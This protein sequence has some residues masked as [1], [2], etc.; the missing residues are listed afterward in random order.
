LS[1]KA[2]EESILCASCGEQT[3]GDPCVRCGDA[4]LLE[5]RYRLHAVLARGA[6]GTTYRAVDQVGSRPVAVKEMPLRL[7]DTV[8]ARELLER[9]ARVLRQLEHPGIPSY[10]EDFVVGVGR[11]RCFYLVQELVEGSTLAEEL[12]GHRYDQ[13]QVLDVLDELLDILAYLHERSPPV[14]HRDVKPR[15]VM[16][17]GD[18]RLVLVDFGSVRDAVR[19]PQIGGSTVAGTFGYMAPE[20]FAGDAWPT[21]DLFGLGALAVALLTRVEP[22]ALADHANR[23]IWAE[24]AAPHPE[25]RALVDWLVEPDM[26]RRAQSAREVQARVRQ[27]RS[28]LDEGASG[29]VWP[30]TPH[31]GSADTEVPAPPRDHTPSEPFRLAQRREVPEEPD[32]PPV[33]LGTPSRAPVVVREIDLGLAER[34]G[35]G[36]ERV[37]R[38]G[39]PTVLILAVG[40]PLV[41]FSAVVGLLVLMAMMFLA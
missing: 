4:A 17:R 8:K 37:S 5:G 18:G 7:A 32:I 30:A 24:H 29:A 31:V 25:V 12:V 13:G 2:A 41:M 14:V 28:V 35:A 34:P 33:L 23:L 20:Q 9:E 39:A 22:H 15:N 26:R 40:V 27:V 10:R 38:L 16:R 3:A 1:G 19:D 11:R 36:T 21:T 6:T